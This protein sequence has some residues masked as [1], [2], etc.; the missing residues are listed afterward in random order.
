VHRLV[1]KNPIVGR[2]ACL[3]IKAAKNEIVP[4]EYRRCSGQRLLGWLANH[5]ADV[6][7]WLVELY[8]ELYS[9]VED[10]ENEK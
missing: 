6:P 2:I 10:I 5:E 7:L 4:D 8:D 1:E 3:V 9:I